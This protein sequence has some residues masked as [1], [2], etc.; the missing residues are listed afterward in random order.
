MLNTGVPAYVFWIDWPKLT[1][2]V[3]VLV[4]LWFADVVPVYVVWKNPGSPVAP[5][6]FTET[7]VSLPKMLETLLVRETVLLVEQAT[8]LDTPGGA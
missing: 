2:V 3:F 8:V 1:V 6:I 5:D 4:E 7:C